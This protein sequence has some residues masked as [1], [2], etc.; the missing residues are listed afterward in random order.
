MLSDDRT[1]D[2]PANWIMYAKSDLELART[3]TSPSVLFETLAFHAQQAAEKAVKALLIARSVPFP[4]THSIR[5]LLELLPAE[6][7]IPDEVF[8]AR[9]LTEYAVSSRY[10]GGWEPLDEEDLD[11]AVQM[12]QSVVLWA[13]DEIQRLSTTTIVGDAQT[14]L[15]PSVGVET[16]QGSSGPAGASTLPA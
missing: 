8:D 1:P 4:R 6:I 12:A 14:E 3:G 2:N 9:I 13:E 7:D 16:S 15:Q 10:P 5:T 11:K